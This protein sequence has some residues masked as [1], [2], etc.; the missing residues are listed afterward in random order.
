VNASRPACAPGTVQKST[1]KIAGIVLAL[2]A[3][4]T[5]YVKVRFED[6]LCTG[7]ACYAYLAGGSGPDKK[8]CCTYTLWRPRSWIEY[9]IATGFGPDGKRTYKPEEPSTKCTCG[10]LLQALNEA[11]DNG[12]HSNPATLINQLVEATG[13]VCPARLSFKEAVEL[14]QACG[15]MTEMKA[16][17][18]VNQPDVM[19][20]MIGMAG[21]G[22]GI[23][24]PGPGTGSGAGPGGAG[25]T[26]PGGSNFV[27]P[28]QPGPSTS[29]S[30]GR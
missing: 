15:I 1:E 6:E 9:R 7:G 12:D 21:G 26:T 30:P 14:A 29:V 18:W 16:N 24:G 20:S 25:G 17:L 22:K 27:T 5:I 19:N 28:V 23:S 4:A 13:H 11:A 2:D 10:Q 3:N 8:P